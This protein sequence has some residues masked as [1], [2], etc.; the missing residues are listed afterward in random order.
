VAPAADADEIENVETKVGDA[1]PDVPD[2]ETEAD[3]TEKT[4]PLTA[5]DDCREETEM[6]VERIEETTGK[7]VAVALDD[8]DRESAD[9]D[10]L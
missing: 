1:G 5:T 7:S 9:R 8:I 2:T 3:E 6:G 4:V 10:V